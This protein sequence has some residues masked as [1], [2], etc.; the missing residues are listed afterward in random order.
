MDLST[1]FAWLTGFLTLGNFVIIDLIAATTN[2]LNG[3]L[4]AQR[5]DYYRE[6]QWTVVGIIL[7][8][9]LAANLGQVLTR[10]FMSSEGDG[11]IVISVATNGRS[12]DPAAITAV[13]RKRVP[14]AKLESVS[15]NDRETV[16]SY[17]F[18]GIS[19]NALA[20]L[21]AELDAAAA[22]P[23]TFNVF[24]NRPGAL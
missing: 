12:A 6:K 11:T 18:Q 16:V 22:G 23:S 13:L 7:L 1:Y 14:K 21:Q 8:V 9:A 24:F 3:A 5:P 2:A 15:Y 19:D 4:L 17:I 20:G 10:R